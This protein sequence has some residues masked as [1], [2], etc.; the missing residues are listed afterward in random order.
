M[1]A[2]SEIFVQIDLLP[3]RERLMRLLVVIE[4]AAPSAQLIIV[5]LNQIGIPEIASGIAYM[6]VFQ[7]IAS[8]FTLTLWASVGL[9]IIYL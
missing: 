8:I 6:F 7:Y 9:S 5:S 3:K 2:I 1:L 4:A